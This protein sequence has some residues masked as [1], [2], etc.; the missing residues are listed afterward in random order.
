MKDSVTIDGVKLTA[1][2][3]TRAWKELQ[4]PEPA[5]P[6]PGE[7]LCERETGKL[8]FLRLQDTA[9]LKRI[10]DQAAVNNHPLLVSL[11]GGVC[12]SVTVPDSSYYSIRK[13]KIGIVTE[14]KS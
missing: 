2:Q 11:R 12:Y 5:H 1:D 3:V 13:G 7:W 8:M 6:Q 4:T 14:R 9:A 10:V